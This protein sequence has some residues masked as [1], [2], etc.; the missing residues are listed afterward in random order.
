MPGKE[1]C[2]L[3]TP[4][5][6]RGLHRSAPGTQEAPARPG[7][8]AGPRRGRRRSRSKLST[9]LAPLPPGATLPAALVSLPE[10]GGEG[11]AQ[12][13]SARAFPE[14]ALPGLVPPDL[15]HRHPPAFGASLTLLCL[16]T[17][18]LSPLS[19]LL[20]SSGVLARLVPSCRGP[21]GQCREAGAVVPAAPHRPPGSLMKRVE[22]SGCPEA[23]GPDTP[24]GGRRWSP[25][26]GPASQAPLSRP[27]PSCRSSP[28]RSGS[29]GR[30]T[31]TSTTWSSR[32]PS[33]R[34]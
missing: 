31:M 14:A 16:C 6:D 7:G 18:A 29:R 13:C 15:C 9:D 5:Q 32:P 28:Q 30:R 1:I 22:G 34:W 8:L 2:H 24:P 10:K 3:Q 19:S 11:L 25:G 23:C 17:W 33:S 26:Q 4:A 12:S 27:S 20:M 21:D